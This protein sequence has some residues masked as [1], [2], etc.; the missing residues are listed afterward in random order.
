MKKKKMGLWLYVRSKVK[1]RG[2]SGLKIYQIFSLYGNP[3]IR[4]FDVGSSANHVSR[5]W[6]FNH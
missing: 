1:K 4:F 3:P 2:G 5:A 6:K